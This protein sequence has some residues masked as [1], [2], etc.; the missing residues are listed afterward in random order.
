M[1]RKS[2]IFRPLQRFA[3][4]CTAGLLT[5]VAAYAAPVVTISAYG[6][7]LNSPYGYQKAGTTDDAEVSYASQPFVV[8]LGYGSDFYPNV[9]YPA[10]F[11]GYGYANGATGVLKASA[12]TTGD[13]N[14]VPFEPPW[15][16]VE[17]WAT[18]SGVITVG[19]VDGQ[20]GT[21]TLRQAYDGTAGMTGIKLGGAPVLGGYDAWIGYRK[22]GETNWQTVRTS[23]FF[24]SALS[25]DDNNELV[26]DA[27]A[28]ERYE[29]Y[30][31]LMARAEVIFGATTEVDFSHTSI[32]SITSSGGITVSGQDGFLADLLNQP[33]NSVPEPTSLALLLAGLSAG[34]FGWRKKQ[35]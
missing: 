4:A 21:V 35:A 26:F 19:G 20:T 27:I 17:T 7:D 16:Y 18:A 12:S 33:V 22:V 31:G 25:V 24:L 15:R 23:K 29:I 34:C 10:T 11:Q 28:G 3:F 14:P 5:S 6:I 2:A 9:N 1:D 32:L 30:E 8:P 13:S